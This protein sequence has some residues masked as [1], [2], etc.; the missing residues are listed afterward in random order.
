[1][2]FASLLL[3]GLL[4]LAGSTFCQEPLAFSTAATASARD[5]EEV[6]PLSELFAK[7]QTGSSTAHDALPPLRSSVS[8]LNDEGLSN[9]CFKMR[10]YVVARDNNQSDAVRPIAYYTCLPGSKIAMKSADVQ[11]IPER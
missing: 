2:R 4:G 7:T 3:I 11:V 6:L 9:V 1:M 8:P 10:T 5:L